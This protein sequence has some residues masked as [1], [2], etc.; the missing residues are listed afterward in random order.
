MIETT[1]FRLR[2]SLKLCFGLL[3]LQILRHQH[4]RGKATVDVGLWPAVSLIAE[5][6]VALGREIL[7]ISEGSPQLYD[8]SN[9][10]KNA[11]YESYLDFAS[12]QAASAFL[13]DVC[14]ALTA[15]PEP[16]SMSMSVVSLRPVITEGYTAVRVSFPPTTD[17]YVAFALTWFRKPRAEASDTTTL[18]IV[19]EAES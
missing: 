13:G 6:Q 14:Q 3:G 18:D 16:E 5:D 2:A 7:G 1:P 15:A 17:A 8:R 19:E 4:R 9:V 11:D 12:V 10:L